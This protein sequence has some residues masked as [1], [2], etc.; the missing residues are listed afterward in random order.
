MNSR[1]IYS[2]KQR[3]L[4]TSLAPTAQEKRTKTTWISDSSNQSLTS[5]QIMDLVLSVSISSGNLYSILSGGKLSSISKRRISRIL[6]YLRQTAL[7]LNDLLMILLSREL[8]NASGPG[9]QNQNG[10]NP[11]LKSSNLG[12]LSPSGS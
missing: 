7:Y 1:G 9:V 12:K 3:R 4:V 6:S 11:L 8:T 10:Q 5:Q 2:S